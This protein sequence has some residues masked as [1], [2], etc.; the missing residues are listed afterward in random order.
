MDCGFFEM[1]LEFPLQ[2]LSHWNNS[3]A[4]AGAERGAAANDE[5]TTHAEGSG[6][7][8]GKG[9]LF[10]MPWHTDW[11]TLSYP[12]GRALFLRSASTKQSFLPVTI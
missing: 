1:S 9:H 6:G 8:G 4:T 12:T 3:A 5:A 7:G 11:E 10:F 2:D